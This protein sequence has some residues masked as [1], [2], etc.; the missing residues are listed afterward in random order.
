MKKTFNLI[1]RI[2]VVI[3]VG[4]AIRD[5]LHRPPEERTWQGTIYGFPYDFRFPTIE[6]MRA[7]LWNP[8]TS[9]ILM[10]QPFGVG[11]T[12]NFYPLVHPEEVQRLQ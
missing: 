9:R 2:L 3:L 6:R 11:W 4:A 1:L 12:I 10:P 8:N 5:Q 7:A